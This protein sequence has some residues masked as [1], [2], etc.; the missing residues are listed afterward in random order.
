M[1][2]TDTTPVRS[3]TIPCAQCTSRIH[4]TPTA[5]S[6][7]SWTT[8]KQTQLQDALLLMDVAGSDSGDSTAAESPKPASRA[9]QQRH[10]RNLTRA[11]SQL[12]Q[13]CQSMD[14]SLTIDHTARSLYQRAEARSLHRG[15]SLDASPGHEGV[16][17]TFKEI[18]ALTRLGACSMSSGDLMARFC[19]NLSL[20]RGA[21]ECAVELSR[22]A[23]ECDTLAGKSPVSVAGACIYMASHLVGQPRDAKVISNVAGVSEVTIKNS[24]RLLFA[25]RKRLL[26]DD[27]LALAQHASIDLLPLP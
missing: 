16:P 27:L 5:C 25:D 10:E 11:F 1:P 9:A 2:S 19:A 12:S 8:I 7:H 15:K 13:M 3:P 21:V 17:R 18:C 14:L 26:S 23:R 20:L 22:R 4:I 24:Y 6:C